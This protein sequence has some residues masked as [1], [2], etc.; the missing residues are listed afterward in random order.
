M[1]CFLPIRYNV[2]LTFQVLSLHPSKLG[3]TRV[4]VDLL[5]FSGG[6]GGGGGTPIYWLHEYVLLERV[7]DCMVFKPL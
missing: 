5:L 3:S 4:F 2:K 6:G 1:V 7:Q